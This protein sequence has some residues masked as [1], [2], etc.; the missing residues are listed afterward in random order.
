MKKVALLVIAVFLLTAGA[1]FAGGKAGDVEVKP[2][3]QVFAHYQYNISAYE[4]YDS[5]F[6][7]N[8]HNSFELT[9][10]YLGLNAKWSKHWSALVLMDTRRAEVIQT[11][12]TAVPSGAQDD[13]DTD[14]DESMTDVVT[15]VTN[16]RTGRYEAFLK[17][18][19]GTFQPME[20]FGVSF[21]LLKTPYCTKAYEIWAYRWLLDAATSAYGMTRSSTSDLGVSVQ[22][23]IPGNYGG[24]KVA[25]LSGEPVGSAEINAGKA[26]SLRFWM[27]PFQSVDPLKGF[28]LAGLYHYDKVQPDFV[29]EL[30]TTYEIL[31]GYK[32][33]IDESMGFSVNGSYAQRTIAIDNED[34]DDV[35]SMV[36]AV[37]ADFWFMTKYGVIARYDFFDP[38]TE[39]NEDDNIGWQDERDFLLAGVFY[40]PVKG[41]KFSLNY[42]Q[43]G[44]AAEIL[45][46]KGDEVLM[47]PDKYIFVNSEI[48]F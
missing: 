33:A 26:V 37:W 46:D 36:Y 12:M 30:R 11:E 40:Y 9:R 7:A 20:S 38:N 23:N 5:R 27:A 3:T 41:F 45:D 8:D 6:D 39:N 24:Y 25:L 16:A 31:F 28:T 10:T 47:Q 21:G 14:E 43:T 29:E 48:K 44:Y 15:G 1:A 2:I 42:R 19:F 22:G 35:V 18:A 4:D 17:Y 13:P 32:L 34:I